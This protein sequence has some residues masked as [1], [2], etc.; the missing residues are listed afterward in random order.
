MRINSELYKLSA[1]ELAP[2]LLGMKL[3]RQVGD[4]IIKLRITETEAYLEKMI[5]L[6]MH[7]KER[8]NVRKF[9]I[10]RGEWCMFIYVTEFTTY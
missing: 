7:I 5:Q 2:K 4:R 1:V 10:S 8:P 9:Y 3:C 6:A